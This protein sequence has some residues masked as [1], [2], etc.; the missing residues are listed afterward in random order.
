VNTKF[1][2]P[3]SRRYGGFPPCRLKAL[4]MNFLRTRGDTTFA[5]NKY[6][7]RN[8]EL[9]QIIIWFSYIYKEIL[10]VRTINIF[11]RK[12]PCN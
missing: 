6:C 2:V 5:I 7:I 4:M 8:L 12:V 11:S 9:I 10:S 1:P 3:E